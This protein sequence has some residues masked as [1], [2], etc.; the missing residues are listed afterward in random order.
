MYVMYCNVLQD[1]FYVYVCKNIEKGHHHMWILKNRT[2]ENAC[3]FW[4]AFFKEFKL[5]GWFFIM[6]HSARRHWVSWSNLC[7][8]FFQEI[9]PATRIALCTTHIPSPVDG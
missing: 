9:N 3:L 1:Y 4:L 6:F 5:G 7:Q 8:M 2:S